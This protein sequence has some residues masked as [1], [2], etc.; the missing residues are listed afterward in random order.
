M[1]GRSA[2]DRGRLLCRCVQLGLPRAGPWV[3]VCAG[4]RARSAPPLAPRCCSHGA[5]RPRHALLATAA[6]IVPKAVCAHQRH[7]LA[8]LQARRCCAARAD[9]ATAQLCCHPACTWRASHL[10]STPPLLAPPHKCKAPRA[11]LAQR[12]H[13]YGARY[14]TP[15]TQRAARRGHPRATAGRPTLRGDPRLYLRCATASGAAS[16]AAAAAAT[17]L[18]E[19]WAGR[20]SCGRGATATCTPRGQGGAEAL[21][22]RHHW[23]PVIA[24]DRPPQGSPRACHRHTRSRLH[25]FWP[26]PCRQL[27][28]RKAALEPSLAALKACPAWS[29]RCA[30]SV[31]MVWP[32]LLPAGC[33]AWVGAR[34]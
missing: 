33:R 2:E 34:L 31:C 7:V 14:P 28:P 20:A 11:N 5:G 19:S 17:V 16:T 22:R 21:D 13:T 32:R 26:A 3:C 23:P 6:G 24:K 9:S 27:T 25:A 4:P 1:G 15:R 8:W 29:G 10:A 18:C 30:M 12:V